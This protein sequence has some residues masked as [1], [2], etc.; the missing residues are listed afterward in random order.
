MFHNGRNPFFAHAEVA[1]FLA[2]R[3]TVPCGRI[4]AIIN[5]RHN[6]FHQEKTAFFGFYEAEYEEEVSFALFTAVCD[7][8]REKGMTI[9]RGPMNFSTNETCG[10]LVDGFERD[11]VVMMPYNPAYYPR[12][13]ED[14][15]M[16][17]A[18]D[19]YSYL[20][21]GESPHTK[22]ILR[23]ADAV[24][25]RHS[26]RLRPITKKNVFRILED[27]K[28]IYDRSWGKNWGFVPMTP[29]EMDHLAGQLKDVLEP[30]LAFLLLDG[31]T[32][33]G[34]SVSL[35]DINQVL[36][37]LNGRVTVR[38][39]FRA[40]KAFAAIDTVRTLIMGVAPEY[41]KRGLELLLIAE[42]IRQGMKKGIRFAD[43]GWILE[44]NELMNR[45]LENMGAKI[46]KRYRVYEMGL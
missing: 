2:F 41:R 43:L 39:L 13:A 1:L 5:H 46:Y 24:S 15:G 35:P 23:L 14:F 8:A 45:E 10:M 25:S 17:K 22:R 34:A 33:M 42:T 28:K 16:E 38:G 3:E 12:R 40:K 9:L 4:V 29:A 26:Y 27:F 30:G 44:N 11:P 7:Y 31:D 32:P 6:E 20:Y 37:A 18:M 19:L 36:K 21:D